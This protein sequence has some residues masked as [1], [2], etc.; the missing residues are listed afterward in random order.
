M[1]T[2]IEFLKKYSD[3]PNTFI[4]DF[5]NIMDYRDY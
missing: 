3:I 1:L 2:F 5:Y 4:D